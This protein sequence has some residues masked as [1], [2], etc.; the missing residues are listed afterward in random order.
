M[1]HID[2]KALKIHILLAIHGKGEDYLCGG[3]SGAGLG[4]LLGQN[5]I[6]NYLKSNQKA[7]GIQGKH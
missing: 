5:L 7:F 2:L 3:K 6:Y 4:I 1:S